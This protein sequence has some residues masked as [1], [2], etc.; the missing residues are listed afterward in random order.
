MSKNLQI[1][2][3]YPLV[4]VSYLQGDDVLEVVGV[5]LLDFLVF[6]TGEKQVCVGHKLGKHDT[7]TYVWTNMILKH[8]SGQ[9]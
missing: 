4:I 9:I 2:Y 8:T 5:P 3:C 6:P 1:N 7:E